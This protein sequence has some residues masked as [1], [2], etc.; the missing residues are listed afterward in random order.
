LSSLGWNSAIRKWGVVG[1]LG[2]GLSGL[3][4]VKAMGG[5]WNASG[6]RLGDE[7]SG[8]D[9]KHQQSTGRK[10]VPADPANTDSPSVVF[11]CVAG[12]A[13]ADHR[14]APPMAGK[15]FNQCATEVSENL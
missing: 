8:N 12:V 9:N 3:F 14:G 7:S 11:A 5:G 1:E 15:K 10:S 2:I 6:L 4:L 13:A